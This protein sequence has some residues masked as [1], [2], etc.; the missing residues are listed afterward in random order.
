MK[1]LVIDIGGTYVKVLATGQRVHRQFDSGPALTPK[2]MVSA[3]V[4]FTP[5]GREALEQLEANLC[6]KILNLTRK[7]R[8]SHAKTFLCAAVMLFL[9]DSH[10][11]P[12]L[13]QF[14][15]R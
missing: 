6:F 13:P 12:Q 8:L 11:I 1:V 14:H 7:G 5:R 3:A 2:R 15:N 9:S 4:I 10:K